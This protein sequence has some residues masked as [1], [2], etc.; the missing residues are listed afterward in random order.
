MAVLVT[1][2]VPGQTLEGYEKIRRAFDPLIKHAPGFVLHAVRPIEG[3]VR[4]IEVWESG[5]EANAF[6][7]EVVLPLLPPGFEFQRKIE[8]LAWLVLP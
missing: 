1:A 2:D 3:G 6:F 7:A 4:V 5:D 8:G